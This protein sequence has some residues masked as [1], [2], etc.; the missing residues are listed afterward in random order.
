MRQWMSIAVDARVRDGRSALAVDHS[1]GDS[2]RWPFFSTPRELSVCDDTSYGA[3]FIVR[4]LS[5]SAIQ[6]FRGIRGGSL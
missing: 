5:P 6:V 1:A 2:M 3:G 4:G